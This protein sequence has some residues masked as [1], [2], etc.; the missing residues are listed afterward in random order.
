MGRT[1]AE[2]RVFGLRLR[3]NGGELRAEEFGDPVSGA[4]HGR[5]DGHRGPGE[6]HCHLEHLHTGGASS[7]PGTFCPDTFFLVLLLLL[8]LV[9]VYVFSLV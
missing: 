8:L 9:V 6:L 7:P 1:D 2:R 5:A 4:E 3:E